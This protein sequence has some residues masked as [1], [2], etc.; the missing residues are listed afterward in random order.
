MD[1]TTVSQIVSYINS[2]QLCVLGTVGPDG[3]PFSATMYVVSDD[4]LNL[5]FM[6]KEET[7]KSRNLV[8]NPYVFLTF[9]DEPELSTL[10]ISGTARLLDPKTDGQ[11]SYELLRGLRQKVNEVKLP[12]AKLN[13]GGY[14]IF[15]IEIE[16]ATLTNYHQK[17]ITQ[18]VTKLEY[19][20]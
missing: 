19:L 8:S 5:Y 20:S 11:A 7:T 17:D 14:V 4:H 10:Q 6:T 16:R 13:A 15:K 9:S 2:H 12:V 1:T 3:K 18:G